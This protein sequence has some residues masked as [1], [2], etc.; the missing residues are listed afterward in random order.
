MWPDPFNSFPTLSCVKKTK[1]ALYIIQRQICS[2][3]H[4]VYCSPQFSWWHVA[5]RATVRATICCTAGSC[6]SYRSWL[7]FTLHY[8][9]SIS[10]RVGQSSAATALSETSSNGFTQLNVSHHLLL[11]CF[12]SS[13]LLFRL[14]NMRLREVCEKPGMS[15]AFESWRTE[16]SEVSQRGFLLYRIRLISLSH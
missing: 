7:S 16:V 8:I 11:F 4:R 9:H 15:G 2:S 1:A 14:E 3:S 12:T 5:T 6:G 10:L 13:K